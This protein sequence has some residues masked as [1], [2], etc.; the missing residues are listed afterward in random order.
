M[1]R[2]PP[3]L[4]V[5]CA[6][7]RFAEFNVV[8]RLAREWTHPTVAYHRWGVRV[9]RDRSAARSCTDWLMVRWPG[10]TWTLYKGL[11]V[12]SLRAALLATVCHD[13]RDGELGCVSRLS[14]REA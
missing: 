11:R 8:Q 4:R 1:P 10:A 9:Q 7:S 12:E 13:W 3:R 2:R 14:I 5:E 6:V